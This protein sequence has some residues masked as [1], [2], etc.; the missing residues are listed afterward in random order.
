MQSPS[1]PASPHLALAGSSRSH[2]QRCQPL[3]PRIRAQTLPPC[4]LLTESTPTV[5]QSPWSSA[6]ATC[7]HWPQAVRRPMAGPVLSEGICLPCLRLA[8]RQDPPSCHLMGHSCVSLSNTSY[9]RTK[10]RMVTMSTGRKAEMP[11]CAINDLLMLLLPKP[12]SPG[13]G[14]ILCYSVIQTDGPFGPGLFFHEVFAWYL[15]R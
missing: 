4:L 1:N 5:E 15:T 8:G 11:A 12:S 14:L 6:S 10:E 13:D 9:R 7:W 2:R 3:Q